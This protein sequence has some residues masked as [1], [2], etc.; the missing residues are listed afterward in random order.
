MVKR[1]PNT[2][3]QRTRSSPSALRSPLTRR[4]L[5]GGK[6]QS[7]SGRWLNR[8]SLLEFPTDAIRRVA[9]VDVSLARSTV[10]AWHHCLASLLRCRTVGNRYHQPAPS[11]G[12]PVAISAI[13]TRSG[14]DCLLQLPCFRNARVEAVFV[15]FS[16]ECSVEASQNRI[17]G[18][19]RSRVLG[20]RD[21]D[22]ATPWQL[23][24]A[25]G[26]VGAARAGFLRVRVPGLEGGNQQDEQ[27]GDQQ[28]PLH[29]V[30]LPCGRPNRLTIAGL[31]ERLA[32]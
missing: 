20:Y 27:G 12:A 3:V 7:V 4:P 18:L 31:P 14:R 1:P 26:T 17:A 32:A 19:L 24:M 10:Q 25:E 6:S 8:P 15:R 23:R 16:A 5:G 13:H 29:R 28:Q 21:G 9:D 22:I 2:R 30:S 11:G